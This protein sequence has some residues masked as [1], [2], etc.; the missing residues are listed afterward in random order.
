[1]DTKERD[2]DEVVKE[3]AWDE[4]VLAHQPK[5]SEV[6]RASMRSRAP[7]DINLKQGKKEA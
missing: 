6:A 1:M 7:I 2:E 4:G 5:S 3:E